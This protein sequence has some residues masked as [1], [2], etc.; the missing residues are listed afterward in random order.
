MLFTVLDSAG[1]LGLIMLGV[2]ADTARFYVWPLLL[3][4]N[5]I[6]QSMLRIIWLYG[7]LLPVLNLH[8]VVWLFTRATRSIA[9]YMLRQ[10]SW[11]AGCHSR[12]CVTTKPILKLFQPPGSPVFDPL[13]RYPVPRGTPSA[14]AWNT[15]GR[16]GGK[17][18]RFSTEFA[19]YLGNGAR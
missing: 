7:L 14:G 17:M 5:K 4:N 10:R 6:G 9:W 18:W 19:V 16:G 3:M 15:R 13:C 12:Y 1:R 2:N 11:L 8:T